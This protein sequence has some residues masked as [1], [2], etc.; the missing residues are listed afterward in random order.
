MHH[1]RSNQ[2]TGLS[3]Q[4][5]SWFPMT[6]LKSANLL[7]H[8]HS[9]CSILRLHHY[10]SSLWPPKVHVDTQQ[11]CNCL[12]CN[13]ERN[14][15]KDP[16][17]VSSLCKSWKK[18][19]KKD[20]LTYICSWWRDHYS[21]N[22]LWAD[23]LLCRLLRPF[24]SVSCVCLAWW[25]TGSAPSLQPQLEPRLVCGQS[26]DTPMAKNCRG[27]CSSSLWALSSVLWTR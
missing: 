12:F 26:K 5:R 14:N 8:K 7:A 18:K 22:E 4:G 2:W 13:L 10:C 9:I 27:T 20:F 6:T 19:R 17:I 24:R 1:H 25:Y 21:L 16:I 11:S 15:L 3:L 23:T